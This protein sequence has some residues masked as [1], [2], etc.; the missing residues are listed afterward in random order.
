VFAGAVTSPA[1]VASELAATRG[2]PA[3]VTRGGRAVQLAV[4]SGTLAIGLAVMFAASGLY[5]AFLALGSPEYLDRARR[6]RSA[7]RLLELAATPEGLARLRAVPA[8]VDAVGQD[9]TFLE[10]LSDAIT[11]ERTTLRDGLPGLN[12]AEEFVL[13][14]AADAG[15][16]RATHVTVR[17]SIELIYQAETPPPPAIHRHWVRTCLAILVWPFVWAATTFLLRGGLS[18]WL[19]G[20]LLVGAA[21]GRPGRRQCAARTLL[22]WLPVALLLCASV[23]V[24]AQMPAAVTAYR[25]LWWAAA[26][27]LPAYVAMAL[28][29]PER[30]P[31]DRLLGLWLVPR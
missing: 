2:R 18:N 7:E 12:P 6:L 11:R 23:V 5:S 31:H 3:R 20:I 30:G 9:L 16:D 19:T 22:V 27:L 8:F 26:M 17:E 13:D 4:Q 29:D 24:R 25:G 21:G 1:E 14:R 10:R 15:P 28:I